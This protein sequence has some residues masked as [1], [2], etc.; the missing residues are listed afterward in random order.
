MTLRLEEIKGNVP[1]GLVPNGIPR[2]VPA[3]R[4]GFDRDEHVVPD[5]DYLARVA[6]ESTHYAVGQAILAPRD[7]HYYQIAVQFYKKRDQPNLVK[8]PT[9]TKEVV[10]R[11]GC[12]HE[13][14][15][16]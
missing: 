1:T 15:Y 12:G 8:T 7:A 10:V 11:R 3:F 16:G 6:G 2:I 9:N 4:T 13:D 5:K 14:N